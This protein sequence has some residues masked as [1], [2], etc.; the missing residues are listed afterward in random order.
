MATPSAVTAE[1]ATATRCRRLGGG[2]IMTVPSLYE[3][4]VLPVSS[5]QRGHVMGRRRVRTRQQVLRSWRDPDAQM[6][7][8]KRLRQIRGS[9]LELVELV[10]KM[11][12][13]ST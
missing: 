2:R 11:I 1:A 6:A 5:L 10:A 3:P 7:S 4:A 9:L 13:E 8:S 12:R